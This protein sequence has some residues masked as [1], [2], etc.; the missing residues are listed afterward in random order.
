M[1]H[2]FIFYILASVVQLCYKYEQQISIY[3]AFVKTGK[4]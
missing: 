1:V 2:V 4:R 3:G